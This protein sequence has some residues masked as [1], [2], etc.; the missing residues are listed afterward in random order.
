M[1]RKL[2]PI[3][4]I[5]L[6]ILYGI[7]FLV[8]F[9]GA[10]HL[11]DWDEIIFAESAREMIISGDYMAVTINY[12]PFWEKPPM[13][14]WF[15]VIS[16]KLFGINEFAARFPNAIC[17]IFTLVTLFLAGRKVHGQRFGILW[18]LTY[19]T[20]VLPFFYFQTGIIDPWF[21]FFILLGVLFF[22]FY[23]EGTRVAGRYLHVSLSGFFLGLAVLTKGPVAVLIFVL[24]FAVFLLLRR[25]R[26][27][28]T[29]MQVV[30]FSVVLVL[31][32]G[33][34]FLVAILN[35]NMDVVR[36]FI[37]YQAGLFSDDFAGHGGFPGFH[38]VILLFGTFPAS[39]IMLSGITKKKET[40]PRADTLRTWMYIL[41]ALV[42]IIFSLVQTKL[43]HYSSLAWF[44][45]T[46]L[47][48]WVLHL[49]LDR[50]MEIRR[51][52]VALL[53][54]IGLIFVAVTILIPVV[55]LHPEYFT[56]R[57]PKLSDPYVSG[58]LHTQ[59]GWGIIDFIPAL[60]LVVGLIYAL[61]RIRKRERTGVWA[62]HIITFLF[63]LSSMLLF[64]PKVEKMIQGP[65][66][67]F[68]EKHA[69]TDNR[70]IALG[71][72]SFAPYFYGEWMPG[73]MPGDKADWIN[74]ERDG[75][76][77]YVIMKADN[78]DKV[79]LK[80]P[81]LMILEEEGGFVFAI[82]MPAPG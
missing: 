18:S 40:S 74:G 71:F 58:V 27:N 56:D 16:M 65:A 30:V 50:K 49:W 11:F 25:G 24:A 15:Q 57:F 2:H 70:V 64:V 45:V 41:L 82:L 28:T 35:G 76:P 31:T 8:P 59:A 61:P 77:L 68:L 79:L 39:V 46:F 75:H 48:A 4:V 7:V 34:W 78:S 5:L 60:L 52:Q 47:S 32:G 3:L 23:L 54:L 38:F 36:E 13:F 29:P 62:L 26:I 14:I 21:N 37:A 63:T 22:V 43:V 1:T 81:R 10:V 73:D 12:E 53:G 19:A 20:A 6:I 69:G 33:S 42:L 17:G 9:S 80:Y 44:P 72:R 67:A 55:M 66:I 51:W